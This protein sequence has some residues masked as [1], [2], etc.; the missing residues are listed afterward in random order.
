MSFATLVAEANAAFRAG[1]S[2][3]LGADARVSKLD[4]AARAFRSAAAAATT[5]SDRL[6]L[7]R[8]VAACAYNQCILELSDVK[9]KRGA[10]EALF[11]WRCGL[12]A[13][14]HCIQQALAVDAAATKIG[15]LDRDEWLE[16]LLD[17]IAT[18]VETTS[19]VSC[20]ASPAHF[21]Q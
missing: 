20:A 6:V 3:S 17:T 21:A 7:L 15:D 4:G 10:A 18:W 11:R 14:I 13:A 12:E 19:T 5:A 9:V 16:R 1:K 2:T 8:N